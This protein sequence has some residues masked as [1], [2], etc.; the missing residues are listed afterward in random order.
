MIK[1]LRFSAAA[2]RR[3]LQD[4]SRERVTAAT[5]VP[6]TSKGAVIS[7]TTRSVIEIEGGVGTNHEMETPIALRR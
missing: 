5:S 6:S 1:R 7:L 4:R 2:N 3:Q